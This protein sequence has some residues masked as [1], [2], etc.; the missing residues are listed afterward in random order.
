MVKK[1]KCQDTGVSSDSS[2]TRE[3]TVSSPESLALQMTEHYKYEEP[4]KS[5]T[6][7]FNISASEFESML[8][9]ETER[10]YRT[11]GVEVKS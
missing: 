2:C 10:I 4:H 3:F 7:T 8:K 9:D 1:I 5:N 11:K 6:S